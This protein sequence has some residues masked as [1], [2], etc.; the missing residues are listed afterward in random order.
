MLDERIG[1][2]GFWL[3]FIGFNLAFFPMHISGFLG[4]PR[5]VYTYLEG[6]GLE[7]WNLLSTIG[8]FIL[9]FGVLTFVINLIVSWRTGEDAPDNPWDADT[10]EWAT[11]TPMRRRRPLATD[12]PSSG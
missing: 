5:R 7:V 9:A 4:M 12:A 10:L 11:S 2:I 1:K 6:S 3:T 8:A